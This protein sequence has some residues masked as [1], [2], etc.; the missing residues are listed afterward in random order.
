MAEGGGQGK[1]SATGKAEEVLVCVQQWTDLGCKCLWQ[2][3]H[4]I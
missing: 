2:E 1:H 4:R 3:I